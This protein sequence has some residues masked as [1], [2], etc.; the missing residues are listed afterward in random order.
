MNSARTTVYMFCEGI[1]VQKL[2]DDFKDIFVLSHFRERSAGKSDVYTT[3][4]RGNVSNL[5]P[6]RRETTLS[7]A[8]NWFAKKITYKDTKN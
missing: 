7:Y 1:R 8:G 6:G 2:T 5:S 3:F 4:L